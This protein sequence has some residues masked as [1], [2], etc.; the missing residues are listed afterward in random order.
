MVAAAILKFSLLVITRS[1]LHIFASNL[2]H[3][4]KIASQIQFILHILLL[5]IQD[6]GYRHFK[7]LFNGY[8][9][10]AIACI[11]TKFDVETK[12][13]VPKIK[14]HVFDKIQDGGGCHFDIWFI[15]YNS[16]VT[17]CVCTEFSTQTET[18][19]RTQFCLQLSIHL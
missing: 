14:F 10:V 3:G 1:L 7:F 12:N 15:G 17:A 8:N 9:S 19:S 2:L 13:D 5:K 6:R 16:V 11:G 4:E 18:T